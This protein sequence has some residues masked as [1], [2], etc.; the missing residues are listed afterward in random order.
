MAVVK[1]LMVRVG[2]DLSGF[3][4]GM[5]KSAGA[6]KNFKNKTA[7]AMKQGA[8]NM[9]SLKNAMAQGANNAGIVKLT[10]QI[11][12]LE[13]EQKAL[14]DA[15]F[16]W[17]F[18]GYE[19]NHM[20]L[21]SLKSDLQEYIDTLNQEPEG[22]KQWVQQ[23]REM[24]ER[25]GSFDRW[26]DSL[27]DMVDE[28]Q[29]LGVQLNAAKQAL[30][31]MEAAGLSAG[32]S[33][34]DDMRLK[35]QQLTTSVKDYVES[36][37]AVP[38]PPQ[39]PREW[40]QQLRD[41][42]GQS[43]ALNEWVQ[44][45]WDMVDASEPLGAQLTAAK[46][47][48]KEMEAAGL[49]VGDGDW[50]N[51]YIT[52]QRLTQE[53]KNYKASL[54][55]VPESIWSRMGS[56]AKSVFSAFAT[57]AAKVGTAVSTVW[58]GAKKVTSA[59]GKIG[60]T[61][62]AGLKKV[63]G[64]IGSI[65]SRSRSASGST[66]SL[67]SALKKVG[68]AAIG[69]KLTS[70]MFGRLRSIVSSYIAENSTLQAQ[71]DTL[72]NS[73]G[74]ALAPAINIVTNAFSALMPYIIGVSNAIGT[75]LTNLF[76]TGW[77]TVANGASAA[78][79]ATS[80]AAAAQAD[81]NRT[82]A[83]FDEITK[84]DS[85][86]GGGGGGGSSGSTG[87]TT[88]TISG[89][90]PTWLTDLASQIKAAV[91][92]QDFTGVGII[93]A[94]KLGEAVDWA[95]SKVNDST[96]KQKVRDWTDNTA[97]V[98]NGFFA[99]ITYSTETKESIATSTGN[100]IG[101]AIALAL[102]TVDRFLERVNFTSIGTALAQGLNGAV[103]SLNT[104]GV[105]FG[106]VIADVI[107]SGINTASG[108][109][110]NLD[111]RSIGSLVAK[112]IN[113]AFS[114]I[115]WGQ[116]GTTISNGLKGA[117]QSITTAIQETDWAAIGRDIKEFLVNI[118]WGGI[119]SELA[120]TIG[121]AAGGLGTTLWEAIKDSINGA[122][123]FFQQQIED[124]GGNVV[125][126]VL[127]GIGIGLESIGTWIKDN[128][129]TPFVEGFKSTFSIHSPSTDSTIVGLGTNVVSGIL[130]GMLS[131]LSGIAEWIREKIWTP[132]T[133]AFQEVFGD[134]G[135]FDNLFS[136][137]TSEVNTKV[138]VTG[139]VD[140]IPNSDRR[141]SNFSSVLT[142]W[143]DKTSSTKTTPVVANATSFRDSTSSTKT[144][145]FVAKATSF[146]DATSSTKTTNA[147]VNGTSFRD[148][149]SAT[150]TTPVVAKATTF[151]N[152]LGTQMVSVKANMVKGWTGTLASAL[153]IST[154]SSKLDV[155]LPKVTVTWKYSSSSNGKSGLYY[156]T[157]AATY[158][159]GGILTDA[160]LLGM[161]GN[162]AHI[163]GEAGRE[164]ILPLDRN[165]GWMDQIADRLA[166]RLAGG[167]GGDKNIVVKVVLDGMV[168][169]Q[170]VV[171]NIN[172]QARATG[173][174]PLAA[175]I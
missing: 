21:N 30:K 46:Q 77:T 32:D 109:V 49:G 51:M 68:V 148:S 144:T 38:D 141:L 36:L 56:G 35:V 14:K 83:G 42:Q 27:R 111:W 162:T 170:S 114:G 124:A 107:Q 37:T 145:N 82:L 73:L 157:Y 155:T 59:I 24:G 128:I 84:L 76:G 66:G 50:D 119:M 106:T 168:V 96:F 95:S 47:A 175:T 137:D 40:V 116:A 132:L 28:S 41:L 7:E 160:T 22:P 103:S 171:K 70:A 15:G 58:H 153:G 127:N 174:N 34:W 44:G 120:T 69:V 61:G 139:V 85:S 112:N 23:F 52:V 4:A 89:V 13:A 164:A 156:P 20:L 9:S 163:A 115:D 90:L 17:G 78:A 169:A 166:S 99:G 57:G 31:E 130:N 125:I 33:D 172:K 165:T 158:A 93:L 126:G 18:E 149:T 159:K 133:E 100:L 167:D 43:G 134:D 19:S 138:S 81:Y 2:A 60:S 143:K 8:A 135:F 75:L 87:S 94:D 80:S 105:S 108:F 65:G 173:V 151:Q 101:D 91:E 147:V 54:T 45:L 140:K 92:M 161:T 53:V 113:N 72:K 12:A 62:A 10:D 117:L 5:S 110:N 3:V 150:K 88:T 67:A 129:F 1:N 154:I 142:S 102:S 29:P 97:D 39:G 121:A 11:R 48:L 64:W 86:S 6:T 55:A 136:D 25:S 146:I 98:I 104:S 26:V 131:P 79:A 63:A 71:V 152:S 74:Q 16:T 118:D 123:E 122:Y